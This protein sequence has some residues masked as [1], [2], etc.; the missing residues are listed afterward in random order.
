VE[1][2]VWLRVDR[3]AYGSLGGLWGPDLRDVPD[4]TTQPVL[5]DL[6]AVLV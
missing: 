4:M 6:V 2:T 3:M 1:R 5:L